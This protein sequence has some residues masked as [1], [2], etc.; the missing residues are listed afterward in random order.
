MPRGDG[1]HRA[2]FPHHRPHPRHPATGRA[3]GRSHAVSS[4]PRTCPPTPST[5][6]S[7]TPVWGR[8]AGRSPCAP[9]PAPCWSAPTTVC[10]RWRGRRSAG[11]RRRLRSRRARAAVT[12]VQDLPRA[13]RVRA[14]RCASRDGLPVR[15]GGRRP[16]P[17]SLRVVEL[18]GPMVTP[19][20]VG[21]RV[22]E[23]DAFG[24]VQLGVRMADLEAAGIAGPLTLG[25][26][27]VPLVGIF[28]D[29]PEG[30]LAAIVDS[31][32][33]LALVVNRRQR[34]ADAEPEGR[35][36]RRARVSGGRAVRT[37]DAPGAPRSRDRRGAGELARARRAGEGVAAAAHDHDLGHRGGPDQH[38]QHDDHDEG[39][40][41]HDEAE[42]YQAPSPRPG[43]AGASGV[44]MRSACSRISTMTV[45]SRMGSVRWV[46]RSTSSDTACA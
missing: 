43:A 27:P 37:A 42:G 21:T 40:A 35:Q 31:Q 15:R 1:A 22:V 19:G 4:R 3:A 29:V 25:G 41:P 16:R 32:G 45:R 28:A 36:R 7:S 14:S 12:G 17:E 5:W 8:N 30:A 26:R 34:R 6:R 38:E 44:S 10:C 39:L 46:R 9:R 33:Y 11:R 24:N 20:A 18:P 2:R 13:R 23:I